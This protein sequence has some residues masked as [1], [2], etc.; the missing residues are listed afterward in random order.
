MLGKEGER[1]LAGEAGALGMV[2]G[3]LVAVEA[4]PGGVDVG[5]EL[6]VRRLHLLDA[7]QRDRLVVLAEVEHDRAGRPLVRHAWHAAAV[8]A[9]GGGEGAG[10]RG[11]GPGERAAPAVADD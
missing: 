4:V 9:D 7:I 3:A 11:G 2:R 8:V 1:A 6:R 5:G 10:A